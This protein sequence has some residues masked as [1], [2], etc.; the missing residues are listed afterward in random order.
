MLD[1]GKVYD[2]TLYYCVNSVDELAYGDIWEQATQVFTFGYVPVVAKEEVTVPYESGYITV[3]MIKRRTP[4]YLERIW[5]VS[6]PPGMVNAYKK[7]L[8]EIGVK[9]TRIKTDFFPGA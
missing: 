3:D 6:G 5:Y 8:K 1:S 2:T 7:L 4:D 9:G